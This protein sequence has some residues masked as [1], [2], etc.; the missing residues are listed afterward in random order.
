MTRDILIADDEAGFRALFQ[1]MLEPRGFRVTTAE[2]GEEALKAAMGHD[3]HMIFLD[4]HMPKMT[5]PE[6][7]RELRKTK[8]DQPVVILSSAYDGEKV[9]AQTRALGATAYL[10]KP[11]ETS[12][13]LDILARAVQDA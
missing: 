5:G 8:P 11:F 9:N 6:V 12:A 1:Y 13:I 3:F 7:L 4:V 10:Q 2:N